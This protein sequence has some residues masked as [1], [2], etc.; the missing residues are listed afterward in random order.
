MKQPTLWGDETDLDDA[1]TGQQP[2]FT[3]QAQEDDEQTVL[4]SS[5]V[6]VAI[7]PRKEDSKK[8]KVPYYLTGQY[9]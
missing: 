7:V 5:Q 6:P 8:R 9:A 4:R 2:L 1:L 3:P